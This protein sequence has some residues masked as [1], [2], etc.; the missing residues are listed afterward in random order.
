M[1]VDDK[2]KFGRNVEEVRL[3]VVDGG[4]GRHA[5][6]VCGLL[7]WSSFNVDERDVALLADRERVARM[8]VTMVVRKKVDC[9]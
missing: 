3:L 4:R 1:L 6:V 9:W 8:A 2:T 7:S 5:A